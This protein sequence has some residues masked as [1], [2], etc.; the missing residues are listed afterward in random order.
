[1]PEVPE[2]HEA[3]PLAPRVEWTKPKRSAKGCYARFCPSSEE[4][5]AEKRR[6]VELEER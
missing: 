6:E 3:T 4:Y 2:R 5:I 1:M